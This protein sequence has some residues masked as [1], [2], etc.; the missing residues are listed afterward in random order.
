VVSLS[1]AGAAVLV[2]C[3]FQLRS[4]QKVF[5][6]L[7]AAAY[8][9]ALSA[10]LVTAGVASMFIVATIASEDQRIYN[11]CMIKNKSADY[12]RLVVSGR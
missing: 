9:F 7:G 6:L 3:S 4:M 11:T 5:S 12:C 1:E 8:S 10:S 2:F